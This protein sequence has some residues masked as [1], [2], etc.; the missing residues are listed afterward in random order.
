MWANCRAATD[1]YE[2]F[3][4]EVDGAVRRKPT[5]LQNPTR[6]ERAQAFWPLRRQYGPERGMWLKCSSTKSAQNLR[7]DYMRIVSSQI[8]NTLVPA[9]VTTA[10]GAFVLRRWSL[11]SAGCPA[12]VLVTQFF[13]LAQTGLT[14]VVYSVSVLLLAAR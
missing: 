1:F 6:V 4:S 11:S 8:N 13:F 12:V 3:W 10:R 14:G 2:P 7:G 5:A 9:Y